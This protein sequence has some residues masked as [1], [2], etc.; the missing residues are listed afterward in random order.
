[1]GEV[2]VGKIS[3]SECTMPLNGVVRWAQLVADFS[4]RPKTNYRGSLRAWGTQLLG[5]SVLPRLPLPSQASN[6]QCGGAE[7]QKPLIAAIRLGADNATVAKVRYDE[8][9]RSDTDRHGR[10]QWAANGLNRL[11]ED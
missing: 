6:V 1:M 2:R 8:P 11:G 9:H 10:P 5:L 4:M 3:V 7:C